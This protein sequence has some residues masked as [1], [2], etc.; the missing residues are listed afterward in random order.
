MLREIH[1]SICWIGLVLV[2]SLSQR[3]QLHVILK[4]S[5]I[6]ETSKI[7]CKI[8]HVPCTQII[9]SFMLRNVILWCIIKHRVVNLDL[10]LLVNSSASV[11]TC[12][13][14]SKPAVKCSTRCLFIAL[15]NFPVI[16][17]P[18]PAFFKCVAG[19]KFL[20]VV[21]K[22]KNKHFLFSTSNIFNQIHVLNYFKI[23]TF[24]QDPNFLETGS[25]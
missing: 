7:P 21:Y 15:H 2:F 9:C 24:T 14:L 16:C 4:L 1:S 6:T 23:S 13:Q 18:I 17:C 8:L 11:L 3:Q 22:N 12:C 25:C 20:M 19:I 10:L 5:P